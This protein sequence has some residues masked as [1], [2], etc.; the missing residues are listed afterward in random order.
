M[1]TGAAAA[2]ALVS[3]V[4]SPALAQPFT[5]SSG[6]GSLGAPVPSAPSLPADLA[7][8]LQKLSD[9]AKIVGCN[10]AAV[11]RERL[12]FAGA[13]GEARAGH[14]MT[15]ASTLNIGSVSKTITAAAILQL[16]N[17]GMIDLSADVNDV[18]SRSKMYGPSRVR[19]PHH[20]STPI[21]VHHLLTHLTPLQQGYDPGPYAF[22]YRKGPAADPAEL[23][24]WLH[25]FLTPAPHGWM[26]DPALN[27]TADAPGTIHQY[28]D[29]AY[30]L[31][32]HLVQAVTG[33]YFA[34][35]CREEILGPVGMYGSDFA[36]D[37]IEE[38]NRAHPHAWFENGTK[39]GMLPERRHLIPSDIPDDLTG[40]VE[41]SPYTTCLTPDGGLRS[42][43]VDLAQWIR[44]WLNE[45]HVDGRQILPRELASAALSEQVSPAILSASSG[46]VEFVA[47]GY[48]WMRLGGDAPGVWQHLGAEVGTA[49]LVMLDTVRGVGAAVVSNTEVT[50]DADPRGEMIRLLLDAAAAASG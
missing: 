16:V 14:P 38:A 40:H 3:S 5:G 11:T 46:P 12:L 13:W 20:P 41:Y 26:Y 22:S 49:S 10:V 47:Q 15:T 19:S 39:Q 8:R 50:I 45:G 27:F 42:N 32:G 43:A 34:D 24:R 23:G 48:A 4:G 37:R 33:L 9:A 30:N 6:F 44:M 2:A 29:V 35:Y 36:R 21:T 25:D 31:A 17:R 18:L 7:G 1:G 28:S